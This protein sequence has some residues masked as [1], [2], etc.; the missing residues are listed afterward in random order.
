MSKAPVALFVY[1]RPGHVRRTLRSL[2]HAGGIEDRCLFVFSDGPRDRRDESRVG[3]VRHEV[4]T[5]PWPGTREVVEREENWGLARSVI[6]GVSE[7]CTRFGEVVVLEDDLILSPA[8]MEYADRALDRYRHDERVMHISGYMYPMPL[9]CREAVFMRLIS[10]WGWAT[11]ARAWSRFRENADELIQQIRIRGLERAFSINGSY[12]YFEMLR[13]QARGEID[14]WAVRWYASVFLCNGLSLYPPRSLVQNSGHDGSGV[15]CG[16]TDRY[17]TRMARK[18][19]WHF[20]SEIREDA[21]AIHALEEFLRH[22]RQ[23]PARSVLRKV[24]RLVRR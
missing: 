13:E 5:A 11:W 21:A 22:G 4:R 18:A 8:F 17:R 19:P 3:E 14:S 12:P 9:R 6:T 1:N 10:S 24:K 16:S 23:S 7:L 20:P 15:H 2:V